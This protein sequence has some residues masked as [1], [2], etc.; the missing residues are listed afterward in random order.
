MVNCRPKNMRIT[1]LAVTPILFI[2]DVPHVSL[3]LGSTFKKGEIQ[4]GND[5]YFECTIHANPWVTEVGWFFEGREIRTNTTAGIVISNQSLVL[6]KV[7]RTH[8]GLYSCMATN[9]EGT[10]RSN[11][12]FLRIR[13]KYQCPDSICNM[14]I[15]YN[16]DALFVPRSILRD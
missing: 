9:A 11:D 2:A 7:Q 4:E 14:T 6:Q 1:F 16:C 13:C 8:R 15:V 3:Q 10:G 12:V 5:V